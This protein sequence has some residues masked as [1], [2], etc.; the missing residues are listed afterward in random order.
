MKRILNRFFLLI[1][2]LGAVLFTKADTAFLVALLTA[3]LYTCIHYY[4]SQRTYHLVLSLFSVLL[5]AVCPDFAL[6]FPVF[7]Y[8]IMEDC[9][10]PLAVLAG[11]LS[12]L[13]S[14]SFPPEILFFLALGSI[15][16]LLLNDYTTSY[17]ALDREFKKT[18]D[19]GVEKTIL[20]KE[21][22]QALL[23]KQDYEIYTATLKERNRI[24]REIHDNVG[25]MLSRSILLVGAIRTISSDTALAPSLDHLE[26]TL[27]TAMTNVR[28]SV[29]DL[30]DESINLKDA[31]NGLMKDF[32]FCPIQMDYDMG[33]EVPKSIKYCFISIAKEALNNIIR[34]SNAS[35]VQITVREHP[36]LYQLIVEDNGTQLH[37]GTDS[38]LGLRNMRDRVEAL[39][40]MLQIRTE[41]GFRIFI[42]IPKKEE[43]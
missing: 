39:D 19:E 13:R 31:L 42:T 8:G 7:L 20:L 27:N 23:E 33:Y 16:A 3:A 2:C 22:N 5:I 34:H 30:H 25:H 28:E 24:A 10:Y 14:L 4:L 26:S 11:L 6:F 40:G 21:K 15:L 29:H 1:Y 37:Q 32:T 41:K 38:G 9:C 36:G 18:R 17:E 12:F 35:K 43:L